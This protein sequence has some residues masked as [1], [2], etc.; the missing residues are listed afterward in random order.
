MRL[1]ERRPAPRSSSSPPSMRTE[2]V[3]PRRN[4]KR[5]MLLSV[6]LRG[7]PDEGVILLAG[8]AILASVAVFL[9]CQ[10]HPL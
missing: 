7:D 2:M 5:D 6:A 1:Q 8:A 9:M 10:Q 4:L 3:R